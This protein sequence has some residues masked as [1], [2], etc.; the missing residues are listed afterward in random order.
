MACRSMRRRATQ[1]MRAARAA[2]LS[3]VVAVAVLAA[4][5]PAVAAQTV[6]DGSQSEQGSEFDVTEGLEPGTLEGGDQ[7]GPAAGGAYSVSDVEYPNLGSELSALAVAAASAVRGEGSTGNSSDPGSFAVSMIGLSI[8]FE[9]ASEP[10]VEAITAVGGDVRNVFDGYI[11]ALVPPAALAAL[12]QIPGLTWA[13]EFAVPH[14]DRGRYTSGGVAAHLA[15]AWHTAGITGD[16]VKIGVIDGSSGGTTR[17]GF[18][19]LRSAMASGDLPATVVGRCYK[20]VAL[21]TSDIDDCATAGGD[22]HGMSV[23][24]TVMD[25]APDAS[26]YIS[27]P[28]TW[29]DL[30]RSVE[31]MK[32]Q[33]VEVIVYS[34]AWSYHGA[35]DGTTTVNPSPLNTVK[36]A[37]DNGIVWVNSGGNYNGDTWFGAFTDADNDNIHEWTTGDEYQEFTLNAGETKKAVF[38]RWDDAWGRASR[39]LALLI[40]KN[41]GTASEQ[42]VD[43]LNDEQKGTSGNFPF[44]FKKFTAPHNGTYA[45]VVKKVSGATPNW[46]QMATFGSLA[47][48]TTGHSIFSPADSA[49]TGMLAVGA[50]STASSDI[51]YFSS[52]GPT[53]DGRTKPDIVGADG[54]IAVSGTNYGTSYAA[55]HVAGL[56]ALVR[57]QNP[58]FSPAQTTEYLK[59]HAV[60]RGN[61]YPNN[62]WGHGFAQLP[63]LGC[64]D[65]LN[66]DSTVSGTWTSNCMS[67]VGAQK[68]SR[69]YTFA[70]SQQ[71]TVTIDLSSSVDSYLYLRNGYNNQKDVALH[72]DDNSGTGANARISESLAAGTYT[73][74]ATTAATGQTGTFTLAVSGGL[75]EMSE[76]SITAG[77]DITEGSNATFTLTADPAP[78]TALTA[79]VE[80][81][82][83]G[84]WGVT[85]GTQTVT[86]PTTG[87][88]TLTLATTD[89]STEEYDGSI[90]ARVSGKPAYVVSATAASGTVQVSDDDGGSPCTVPIT[91]DGST[92]SEL[93]LACKS[94]TRN[95][96]ANFFTFSITQ[97]RVVTIEMN[98]FDD[99]YKE[100]TYLYLRQ[101]NGTLRGPA[102]YEDD[103]SGPVR[104]AK[105]VA[106]LEP[107]DYTIEATTAQDINLGGNHLT[108]FTLVVSGLTSQPTEP[109]IG[110]FAA[111]DVTEGNAAT[112]N[113]RAIPAP[114]AGLAVSV[115]IG[116]RGEFGFSPNA[117]S[118]TVTIPTSGRAT[119]TFTSQNDQAVE[120]VGWVTARLNDQQGYTVSTAK[121]ATVGVTD[122]DG[123]PPCSQTLSGDISLIGVLSAGCDSVDIADHHARFYTFTMVE[124][125]TVVIDMDGDM[126][127]HGL[128]KMADTYLSL[129]SGDDVRSG[130]A[131]ANDAGAHAYAGAEIRQILDPGTYTIEARS[132]KA[133]LTGA[134]ELTVEGIKTATTNPVV[135]DSACVTSITADGTF[136]GEWTNSCLS[137]ERSFSVSPY[138]NNYARYFAF[139]LQQQSTL[140]IDLETDNGPDPYLYLHEGRG[141]RPGASLY[142]NDD[143]YTG[144]GCWGGNPSCLD[145]RDDNSRISATLEA[146]WYLIEAT[147]ALL[148]RTG[149]FT[150]KISGLPAPTMPEVSIAAGASITEGGN[151]TFTVT[152]DPAPSASLDVTVAVSQVGDF[153]VTPGSQTV[154]IPTSGNATLTVATADDSVGEYNGTVTARVADGTGYTVSTSAGAATVGVSDDDGDPPCVVR[155]GGNGSVA[156]K[157]TSDCDSTDRA[158]RYARFFTFNLS[159]QSAVTIELMSFEDNYLYLRAG[160]D[161]QTGTALHENDDYRNPGTD[162]GISETLAAGWYTIEATT[163]DQATSGDFTLTVSGLTAQP[164]GPEVSVAAGGGVTEGGDAVFTVTADPAP[165]VPLTVDVT[166]AQSGDFG[167]SPGS[168][169]V[170]VPISGSATLTVA[171][172]NDSVDETDGSVTAT[173]DAGTGYTVSATASSASVAVADDDD[174]PC[175][176][177]DAIAR[178]RA[179]FAWHADNNGGSEVLFWQILSYLG[180]DPMPAPP[181]GTIPASTTPEAVRAFSD[182]KSWPGWAAVNAAMGCHTPSPVVSVTAGGGIG[183]GGDAIFTIAASPAPS[184]ALDVPVAV[185]AVGDF[186]VSPGSHT[187]TIPISG[188]ATLSVA[189]SNDSTD[190]ADGSVTATVGAGSGY[191]VSVTAGTAAVAVRDDDVPEVSI[192]AGADI[193]EGGSASFTVSA[194]PA[195][196]APLTVEVAVS[197]SGDFGV[198][199]GSRQVT[200]PTSGTATLSVATANDSTDEADG[201]VTATVG[202]GQGYTVSATAGTAAVAVRDDDAAP[203]S[204]PVVSITGGSGIGEG[205]DAVFT[206]SAVPAPSAALD[207]AVAVAVSGDFGVSPGSHTVTV[208][209]SGTA[210]LTVATANDSTDEADGSVTAT[211]STGAGYTISATAGSAT[212]AVSD[213]DD[214]APVGDPC[215]AAL[216]GDGSVTGQWAAGCG[217][218]E[219]SGRYAR[220]YAFSL[221]GPSRVTIDLKSSAD[222]FLYLRAGSDQKSGAAVASD[223]DGGGNFDSR[224]SRRLGAGGYTIEATTYHAS[225]PGAFTLTVDGIGAQTVAPPDPEIAIAAGGG[226]TEGGDAVFTV[227]AVPAPSAALDVTVAVTAAGDFGVSPGSHTV[228][229]PTTGTATLTL[230]TTND[231]TD[232]ADGSVT[233]TVSA[234]TGYTVSATAGTAAVAVADDDPPP[235]PVAPEV[236]V[237]AGGGVTEGGD[238]V[239][240]VTADPAPTVPLTVDVTVAQSGDFGV[241][242][243]SHAVTVPIS[244]SATLTVATVN[245]SVDETDGSV[246]A[247]VDA[248]TGYTVSATASSASV[249][250]ADDDDPAPPPPPP[251]VP[252]VAVAAGGGVTEGGDAV[253]TVTADP[254]PSAPLTVAVSVAQSGDFGA[255]TGTRQVTVPATGSATLTV[256]TADDSTDEADGSVTVTIST[257]SGWTVSATA[258]TATVAVADDDDPPAPPSD[259]GFAVHDATGAEGESLRFR[260]TLNTA[261]RSAQVS[262]YWITSESGGSSAATAGV[263]Y[264]SGARGWLDFGPG[265][266][267]L[268]A[269]IPLL[270][271]D[272]QEPQEQFLVKLIW[273]TPGLPIADGQATMTITD[274]D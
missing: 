153:G 253:F 262:A 44:E 35:A 154:T 147:T 116:Q 93:T 163:H 194:V 247:T 211:V 181:G 57:Q 134:F 43:N 159:Q 225:T 188:S 259:P 212:V 160:R 129:R 180:A 73:I 224:I 142:Q 87:T 128:L 99:G 22:S 152:A 3:A 31:W 49:H 260:V 229:V 127:A 4:G 167:V 120:D 36:W 216:S 242:P 171:T 18:T 274:N 41:P 84:D 2:A 45:F 117:G 192:A 82:A 46:I 108:K 39:D 33:G 67:A 61:P 95:A 55:P 105:I 30:Q 263:D 11:E 207:V 222:T 190:E 32:N 169:A 178:A 37:A 102:L 130:A 133:A 198:S 5:V 235:A 21:A 249:A 197:Q 191:T 103:D 172:V 137:I 50:A 71:S 29:G 177:A 230:T 170:T 217:S 48:A 269:Q 179:A 119:L 203:V 239:F 122:D 149:P 248:G 59:T 136:S 19:G 20:A 241:S 265:D 185:T 68:S 100:D 112:F 65:R 123:G 111:G 104:D 156:S 206:V 9:G 266:T 244:G 86:I 272:R 91:G 13:R 25:V 214:P 8:T 64:V 183:E 252:E 63:P 267:E 69:Y 228:T 226:V 89:D 219:R 23:A 132:K 233:A 94:F 218:S 155:L 254:A 75:T 106:V 202:S 246:T 182:G 208:P 101:G 113:L 28:Y 24:A 255:A 162:A 114:S 175:D 173:V 92:S 176:T 236:S 107:G 250:V 42:V 234:G 150:L 221:D 268:W 164:T 196:S 15:S 200:V 78:T 6:D 210:T 74:E 38:M 40:V 264:S 168:H 227:T 58:A 141:V 144:A 223:D 240:T 261:P 231:T 201:S 257:G 271:D 14:K 72:T 52:L 145:P 51:R 151:A 125:G 213:D 66:G 109:H 16:G 166:V 232:E 98:A 174:P 215:V 146:G 97:P 157:W 83:D 81:T 76:V 96:H 270:E 138:W 77:A 158:N 193:D 135:P 186:G 88:A 243:G 126:P 34:I 79:T 184:A 124:R 56:A 256:S 220:F 205:G 121:S 26:L 12:A 1:P 7:L 17:D 187:V 199:P 238:A 80:I 148:R 273:V 47:H 10:V 115:S 90:T 161:T 60:P 110:V 54:Y 204:D 131:L 165:T 70:I 195:P 62:T 118:R 140:T 245:D 258:G 143:R 237:A 209:T 85:P 189:T 251:V 139:N 53:P 27:N